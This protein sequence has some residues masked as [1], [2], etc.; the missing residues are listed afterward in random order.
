MDHV[1]FGNAWASVGTDLPVDVQQSRSPILV[2]PGE[3][4]ETPLLAFLLASE[5]PNKNI[6]I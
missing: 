6:S 3:P 4:T 5:K 1:C 2:G